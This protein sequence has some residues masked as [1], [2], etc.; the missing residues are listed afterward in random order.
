LHPPKGIRLYPPDGGKH[1]AD[2]G[3]QHQDL[4][5][6]ASGLTPELAFSDQ[7]LHRRVIFTPITKEGRERAIEVRPV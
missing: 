6:H 4:F 2:G 5:F 1:Q 3:E 7:L